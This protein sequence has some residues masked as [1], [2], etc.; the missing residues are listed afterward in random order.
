MERPKSYEEMLHLRGKWRTSEVA[1]PCGALEHATEKCIGTGEKEIYEEV[2]P[3]P[4]CWKARALTAFEREHSGSRGMSTKTQFLP[5]TYIGE[6][7]LGG[8]PW[9]RSED[10]ELLPRQSGEFKDG[11]DHEEKADALVEVTVQS[12]P[13]PESDRHPDRN[14]IN[15]DGGY[16]SKTDRSESK[17]EG[18]N[19]EGS[20]SDATNTRELK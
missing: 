10:Y 4:A 7:A 6:M 12:F 17:G 19:D 2:V 18:K 11:S 1:A 9:D 16:E 5:S 3:A 14:R 20:K 13:I 15:G 8:S